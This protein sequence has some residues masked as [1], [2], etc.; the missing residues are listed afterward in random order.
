MSRKSDVFAAI[1]AVALYI[2]IPME[3]NKMQS[4]IYL[5]LYFGIAKTAAKAIKKR[6]NG[7]LAEGRGKNERNM[8][9]RN[10]NTD[11]V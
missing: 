10:R 6:K 7:S 2:S 11:H 4:V 3:L 5:A 9:S 1:L 8:L